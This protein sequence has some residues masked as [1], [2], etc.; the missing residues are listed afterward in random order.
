MT[1]SGVAASPVDPEELRRLYEAERLP[2]AEIAERLGVTE[3]GIY[4]ALDR[5]GIPPRGYVDGR[6]S[7][8]ATFTREALSELL[9][10]G[11]APNKIATIVGC[12]RSTVDEWMAYH[13][14]SDVLSEARRAEYRQWYEVEGLSITQVAERAGVGRRTAR[15][16]LLESGVTMRPRG[17]PRR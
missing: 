6:R 16:H 12:D 4:R 17:R 11:W 3:S 5:H 8:G 9:G 2:V 14:L 7:W 15:R 10:M 13:G 1:R